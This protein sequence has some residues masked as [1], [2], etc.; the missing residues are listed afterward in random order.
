MSGEQETL[1]KRLTAADQQIEEIA[2]LIEDMLTVSKLGSP[3]PLRTEE[4]DLGRLVDELARSVS[5]AQRLDALTVALPG[6]PMIARVDPRQMK[7]ALGRIL[8]NAAKYGGAQPIEVRLER[9]ASW[10]RISVTDHG[11]GIAPEHHARIFERFGRAGST[12][13]YGGLGLGLWIA[14][15][16]VE[17]HRG[18]ID[19]V[20]QLGQGAT[21]TVSLPA[22]P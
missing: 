4:T 2:R 3:E 15:Q 8:S 1:Q 7:D 11:I 9:A 10:I 5:V 6:V 19:V 21:F 13:N 18:T 12:R 16:I 14:R 17:A 22:G 20:S